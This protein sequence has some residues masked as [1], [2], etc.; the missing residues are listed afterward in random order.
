MPLDSIMTSF[1]RFLRKALLDVIC[2]S[3]NCSIDPVFVVDVCGSVPKLPLTALND[4]CF[5]MLPVSL[6]KWEFFSSLGLYILHI[7]KMK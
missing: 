5:W 6:M 7:Q 1:L 4:S 2:L 3:S